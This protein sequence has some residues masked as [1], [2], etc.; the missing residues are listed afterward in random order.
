MTQREMGKRLKVGE[1]GNTQSMVT[2][3]LAFSSPLGRWVLMQKTKKAIAT[4]WMEM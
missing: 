2:V 3:S 4:H 1:A